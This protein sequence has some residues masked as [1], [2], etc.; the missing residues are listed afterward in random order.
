M[1]NYDVYFIGDLKIEWVASGEGLNGDYVPG[2]GDIELLR[3]Y[4]SKF[5]RDCDD[6]P[7]KGDWEDI[8]DGSYCTLMPVSASPQLRQKSLEYIAG[9][10]AGAT[11]IKKVLERVSWICPAWFDE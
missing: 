2:T 7:D 4:V 6:V 10:I 9:Q 8:Q 11:N 1:N 3:F 5:R